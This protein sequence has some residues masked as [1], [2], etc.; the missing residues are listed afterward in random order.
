[1]VVIQD[2]L[3]KGVRLWGM[4]EIKDRIVDEYC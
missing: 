1:M 4:V 2:G 3:D